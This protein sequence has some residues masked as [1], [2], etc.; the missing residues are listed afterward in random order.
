[1][2]KRR[3]D[4]RKTNSRQYAAKRFMVLNAYLQI[5]YYLQI[6]RY[7][8]AQIPHRKSLTLGLP[9]T[10]SLA[11]RAGIVIYFSSGPDL[12]KPGSVKINQDW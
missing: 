11:R 5:A 3:K 10:L 2:K 6:T 7:G 1:M 9:A 4:E 12:E 8:I